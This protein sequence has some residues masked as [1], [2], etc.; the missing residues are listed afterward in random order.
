MVSGET[1]RDDDTEEIVRMIAT[2]AEQT[3]GLQRQ[4][5]RMEAVFTEQVHSAIDLLR[6][7]EGRI[8]GLTDAK[9]VTYRTLIDS[10]AE[11]VALALA[12]AE[13]AIDKESVA[14]SKAID[15]ESEANADRFAKVNEFRAQQT[16]L[17]ARFATLERV[18]LLYSQSRQRMEEINSNLQDRM[19]EVSARVVELGTRL[20]KIEE[21]SR[22][23]QGNRA[24]LYAFLGVA[25]AVIVAVVVVINLVTSR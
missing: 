5:S 9:F 3:V 22:G 13:K 24:G 16:E 20:T 23:A 19:N 21:F 15:K 14:T 12:A 6:E 2:L 4:L 17:I 18:D 7:S 11:K 8:T 10:Q 1:E 25:T